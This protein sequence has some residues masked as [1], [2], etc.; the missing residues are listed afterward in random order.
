MLLNT[1]MEEKGISK[2]RLSKMCNI[3]YMTISDICSQRTK[4]EN[5]SAE[6]VYKIAQALEISMED[7]VASHI[8]KTQNT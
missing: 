6:T 8:E 2:Y 4:L 3:P 7:L 1:I 5:C